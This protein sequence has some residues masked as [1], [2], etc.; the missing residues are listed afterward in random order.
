MIGLAWLGGSC[1]VVSTFRLNR[2]HPSPAKF[3]ERLAKVSLHEVG[4]TL[5][6]AYCTSSSLCLMQDANGSIRTIDQ[7]K[8]ELCEQCRQKIKYT[9]I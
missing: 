4:H 6:L 5:G 1:G 2:N 3:R 7:E 8:K 9:K